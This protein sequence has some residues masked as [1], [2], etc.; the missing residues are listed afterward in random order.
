MD[1]NIPRIKEFNTNYLSKIKKLN[2]HKGPPP[3]HIEFDMHGSCSRRCAF[4]PRVDEKKWPNLEETFAVSLY[5][6]IINELVRNIKVPLIACGGA[7]STDDF[8][9]AFKSGASAVAAAS[10]FV[11]NGK[12]NAVLITY[13]N[14]Q[15][16]KKLNNNYG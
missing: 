15:D 3:A 5:L 11:Y 1:P 2:L 6:K 14:D 13:L 7:N 16:N 12:H 9:N 4:C 8:I 10:K